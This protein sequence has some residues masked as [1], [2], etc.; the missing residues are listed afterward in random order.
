MMMQIDNN[1]V[2]AF[3]YTLRN[4]Q[5]EILD[6]SKGQEP[7]VY[8][9]GHGNIILGLEDALTGKLAGDQLKVIL[10]PE[11]AYGQHDPSLVQ[12]VKRDVFEDFDDLK[13]GM[14][15]HVETEDDPILVTITQIVG[16][17]ITLDGNHPL[18]GEN[19]NFEVEV[20]EVRAAT[21]QEMDHGH[22]HA[23]GEHSH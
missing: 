16:E 23:P 4:D 5:G 13:V 21:Q 3:H 15:F 11:I 2:V 12:T 17:D 1:A 8:L 10:T 14:R 6:K 20:V 9:H 18:A 22:A 19:L 7:L